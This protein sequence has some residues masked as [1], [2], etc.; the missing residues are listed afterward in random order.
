MTG[1][2]TVHVYVWY[3]LKLS[4][5]EI[6]RCKEES[7]NYCSSKSNLKLND[8]MRKL[9]RI[10]VIYN[11]LI[12]FA[13]CGVFCAIIVSVI[14]R[15]E[16][17]DN[18]MRLNS[19]KILSLYFLIFILVKS[20]LILHLLIGS[21]FMPKVDLGSKFPSQSISRYKCNATFNLHT[22]SDIF[23]QNECHFIL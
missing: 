15:I 14:N 13:S 20:V 19:K 1:S 6:S 16:K 12:L 18:R 10:S 11:Y 4:L 17:I 5:D 7:D 8:K 23:Y 22:F 9:S 21:M 3:I 2:I